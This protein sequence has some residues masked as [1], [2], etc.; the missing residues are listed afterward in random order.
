VEDESAPIEDGAPPAP[1]GHSHGPGVFGSVTSRPHAAVTTWPCCRLTASGSALSCESAH[2]A[3]AAA[4]AGGTVRLVTSLHIGTR[5]QA[6]R[7]E[8]GHSGGE[9]DEGH[10]AAGVRG[11]AAASPMPASLL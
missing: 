8:S 3:A 4:A 9:S 11:P 6:P 2:R 1:L 5:A 10:E 7:W